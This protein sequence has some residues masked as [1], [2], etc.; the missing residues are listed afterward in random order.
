MSNRKSRRDKREKN[1]DAL[2]GILPE[3]TVPLV[4]FSFAR[5]R[6][7]DDPFASP[8][9]LLDGSVAEKLRCNY[10]VGMRRKVKRQIT[11]R[12]DGD[13]VEYFLATAKEVG[14]PYQTLINLYLR[15]AAGK[16]MRLAW[17]EKETPRRRRRSGRL[18]TRS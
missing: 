11:I 6:S 8:P 16:G 13:V 5:L 15:D 14:V 12:L 17:R 4:P 18:A 1:L 3:D 9:A 7:V 10:S 2:H